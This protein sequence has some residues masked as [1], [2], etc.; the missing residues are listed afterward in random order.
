MPS[1]TFVHD[2]TLAK[3][4]NLASPAISNA[5]NLS[6]DLQDPSLSSM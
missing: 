5:T 3:V 4:S 6:R 2:E 1:F